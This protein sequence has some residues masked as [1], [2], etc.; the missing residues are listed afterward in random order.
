MTD[1][2]PTSEPLE[3]FGI[4]GFFKSMNGRKHET[5]N[6]KHE[7]VEVLKMFATFPPLRISR[8]VPKTRESA[9]HM[10][11]THE[12][13]PGPFMETST[14][15]HTSNSR[16]CFCFCFTDAVSEP[17]QE[18]SISMIHRCILGSVAFRPCHFYLL[19]IQ[20]SEERCDILKA[21]A[22]VQPEVPRGIP[23]RMTPQSHDYDTGRHPQDATPL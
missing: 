23:G 19:P 11:R 8:N 18:K 12:P 20:V 16:L 10:K 7:A 3:T 13:K 6:T 14:Y 21:T 2:L 9:R 1:R 15:V 17:F 5:R 4:F 22:K